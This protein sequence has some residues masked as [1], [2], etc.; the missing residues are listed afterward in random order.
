MIQ[1]LEY[2]FDSGRILR[3]RRSLRRMLQQ[4]DMWM[5]KR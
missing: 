3:K 4:Q 1:E 5:E 2:P